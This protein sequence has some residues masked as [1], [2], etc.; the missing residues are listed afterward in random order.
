MRA[1]SFFVRHRFLLL[2]LV[3]AV[4]YTVV[5]FVTFLHASR[6]GVTLEQYVVATDDSTEYIS[7]A[8][9][10]LSDHRFALSPEAMPEVFRAPGYPFFLALLLLVFG[11]ILAIPFVQILLAAGSA[12]LVALLGERYFSRGL[13]FSTAILFACEPIA[14][15]HVLI[16]LSETL[17]VF[18]FLL[19]IWFL[20]AKGASLRHIFFAGLLVGLSA[21]VRPIGLYCL[22]IFIMWVLWQQR[23][24]WRIA[25]LSAT[26]L[27]LGAALAVSP[28]MSRNKIVG[29]HYAISSV[30]SFNPLFYSVI[31]FESSRRGVL[32]A[33]IRQELYKQLGTDSGALLQSFAYA[34]AERALT[35][36]YLVAHPVEYAV[37]H[38]EKTVPFFVGSGI[39]TSLSLVRISESIP[40][41]NISGMIVRGDMHGAFAALTASPLVFAELIFWVL[42]SLCASVSL[43]VAWLW[44]RKEFA[45]LV[46]LFAI[47]C[48]FAL[49]TGPVSSPRYRLPVEPFMFLGAFACLRVLYLRFRGVSTTR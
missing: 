16:A 4:A 47:V 41:T 8:R 35:Q 48:L 21:L 37:F 11:S 29:E 15:S 33:V 38:I 36:K 7:I 5:F 10:L 6:S 42:I 44:Q 30:S 2:G 45:I 19:A 34:D 20:T 3:I 28:W 23:H 39:G 49:A 17:F 9:T 27:T 43:V 1:T 18:L 46:F 31:S 26:V 12:V 14:L 13:G 24:L 25:L 22:P 32:E 40:D